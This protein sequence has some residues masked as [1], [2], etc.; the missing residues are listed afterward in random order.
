MC[1]C[2]RKEKE[3]YLLL[4]GSDACHDADE[5]LG[6][7]EDIEELQG[8]YEYVLQETKV[9]TGSRL[10]IYRFIK[11]KTAISQKYMEVAPYDLWHSLDENLAKLARRP[12]DEKN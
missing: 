8:A 12:D 3:Y 9:E 10:M 6:I 1:A 7:Y 2:Q 4:I 11:G 5:W